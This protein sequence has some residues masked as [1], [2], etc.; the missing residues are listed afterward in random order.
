MAE[1]LGNKLVELPISYFGILLEANPS[2]AV[3]WIPVIEKV[4]KKLATWKSK[5]LSK[6]GRMVRIKSV[7]NSLPLYYMSL[8][9]MR[10][11]VVRQIILVWVWK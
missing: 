6:E 9:K 11:S 7:L 8:F 1:K 2:K 3:T 4:K 10:K 5:V